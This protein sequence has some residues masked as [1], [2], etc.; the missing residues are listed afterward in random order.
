MKS[1]KLKNIIL[2]NNFINFLGSL[3]NFPDMT[4]PSL[5]SFTDQIFDTSNKYVNLI[6]Q[7]LEEKYDNIV[8]LRNVEDNNVSLNKTLEAM[9]SKKD[10]IFN[11]LV[12]GTICHEYMEFRVPI[13]I[14]KNVLMDF[15]SL[16]EY[17]KEYQEE[18]NKSDYHIISHIKCQ[19]IGLLTDGLEVDSNCKIEKYFNLIYQRLLNQM[20]KQN[21]DIGFIMGKSYKSRKFES[22]LYALDYMG[23]VHRNNDQM[24]SDIKESLAANKELEEALKKDEVE[25]TTEFFNDLLGKYYWYLS[26]LNQHGYDKSFFEKENIEIPSYVINDL[27][28]LNLLPNMNID[29]IF[30][31]NFLDF[32]KDFAEKI[33][34][35]TLVPHCGT[36]ERDFAFERNIKNYSNIKNAVLDLGMRQGLKRTVEVQGYFNNPNYDISQKNLDILNKNNLCIYFD[37]ELVNSMV[38]EDFKLFPKSSPQIITVIGLVVVFLDEIFEIK[39]FVVNGLNQ[40]DEAKNFRKFIKYIKKDICQENFPEEDITFYH[41]SSAEHSFIKKMFQKNPLIKNEDI[42]F[43]IDK[44]EKNSFDLLKIVKE[45][46]ITPAET[47][48]KGLKPIAKGFYKANKIPE[49]WENSDIDGENSMV[50]TKKAYQSKEGRNHPFMQEVIKYNKID[51]L[52]MFFI[53]FYWKYK[54]CYFLDYD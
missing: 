51:C 16:D 6:Y 41:Y 35:I 54:E 48:G 1:S 40:K 8:D 11:G 46:N 12:K 22:K 13:L 52:V 30:D 4:K 25:K 3:G 21:L 15:Y 5:F 32:K 31:D 49:K 34:E 29:P 33:K 45:D 28:K 27:H 23:I 26:N 2:N 7:K 20:T 14:R 44:I 19:S 50:Y 42:D 39:H 18:I 17:I 38:L 9:E 43:Y 53:V 36:D 47:F 10:L 37:I 24:E